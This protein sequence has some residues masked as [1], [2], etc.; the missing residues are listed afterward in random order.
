MRKKR[1]QLQEHPG[2]KLMGTNCYVCHSPS[3]THEN[4]IVPPMVAVKNHYK[5]SKTT[6]EE[7]KAAFQKWIENPTEEN[8]KM[9]GAVRKFGVM[10]KTPFPKKT[11]NLIADYLFDNEIDKPKGFDKQ[12]N[13]M[14]KNE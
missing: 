8:S 6:K 2:K 10:P 5:S 14:K 7:F 11:I 4:R 1:E 3:A 13:L 9:R 12:H